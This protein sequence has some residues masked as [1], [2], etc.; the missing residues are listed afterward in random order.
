MSKR[1]WN[2]DIAEHRSETGKA[3]KRWQRNKI[4][5]N[6]KA[7][8]I[9]NPLT[10]TIRSGRRDTLNAAKNEN[11]WTVIQ[12][13]KPNRAHTNHTPANVAGLVAV[14]K[15]KKAVMF[16]QISFPPPAAYRGHEGAPGKE[17]RAHK[18]VEREPDLLRRALLA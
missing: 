15:A 16:A 14:N 8:K 6:W 18:P 13:T 2:D 9:R 12:Y 5:E 1:W 7:L 4:N 17:G 10:D 11:L 3:R